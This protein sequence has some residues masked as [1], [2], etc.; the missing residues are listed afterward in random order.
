M[1]CDSP[2]IG[3]I[4]VL[5]IVSINHGYC[6]DMCLYIGFYTDIYLLSKYCVIRCLQRIKC[7]DSFA[8]SLIFLDILYVLVDI[9]G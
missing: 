7:A 6:T 5:N 2:V 8:G 3:G 4:V 1:I 9:G